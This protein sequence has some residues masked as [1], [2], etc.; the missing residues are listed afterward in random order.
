MDLSGD[1]SSNDECLFS[2]RS[3]RQSRKSLGK[4]MR[5]CED[6]ITSKRTKSLRISGKIATYV[7]S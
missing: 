3:I 5:L 1:E 4:G 6:Q 7:L 2:T